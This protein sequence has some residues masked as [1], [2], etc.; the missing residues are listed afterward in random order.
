MNARSF[1]LPSV[2]LAGAALL[3]APLRPSGAFSKTGENL[4]VAQ[5]DFR[6]FDNFAD[7]TANDNTTPAAMFPGF[8]G[9]EMALWKGG[10]EWGSTL[11]GD[12]SGDPVGNNL[13][14]SGGANFDAFWAGVAS[15]IGNTNDNIISALADCGGGGTLA[16]TELPASNGWRIR[17]CDEWE[18]DDG[19]GN[20]PSGF[21]DLQGVLTH[22]YGHA[23]GLGHSTV[24]GATMAPS[25]IS[26]QESLR[27]LAADDI[28][29]I[30]C[31]YGPAAASKPTI[32]ATVA[33]AG[34][35]S[36]TIYGTNFGATGNEVWFTAAAATPTSGDPIVRITGVVST[37]GGT[38]MVTA[39]P[40]DAGPGDVLVD[41]PGTGGQT[42]SNAFPTDLMG[43]IGDPPG[44]RPDI[45]SVSPSTIEALIPGTAQTVTISGTNLDLATAVLLDGGV[46]APSRYT[47]VDP[48]TITL[49]M[50]Q[51]DGLGAHDLGVTDGTITDEFAITLVV[52]PSA[53]LEWGNGDPFN[54]V[55]RND[56]LDMILAGQ[57]GELHL[58][59]GSPNGPPTFDRFVRPGPPGQ[60]LIDAGAYVI[61][62]S[63]WIAVHQGGLPDPA[64]V[65]AT[66][67]AKSFV[68]VPPRP[69]PESNDQS[70]TLVP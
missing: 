12:G 49:D 20:I 48:T 9:A 8:L 59:R 4:S 13:L 68:M 1:V 3:F 34:A 40:T 33:D 22:E 19:P 69:F 30:Q 58:V 41:A 45:A 37:S 14:G 24:P 36:L 35:G 11:H 61:P 63:G 57:V 26:G 10:V 62:S 66:W 60:V 18:W 67:F 52:V 21:F 51:A 50:P 15:G 64:L 2:C 39:I 7:A 46:I 29:G 53:R 38:V 56:G 16:F 47:I 25:G 6:V 65:G 70:I 32:T 23:L 54:V 5:R 28:L 31:I 42:L 27:S 44:P 43:T 55:D 17:F